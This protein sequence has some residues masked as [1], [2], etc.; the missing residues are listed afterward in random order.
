MLDPPQPIFINSLGIQIYSSY[1]NFF[2]YFLFPSSSFCLFGAKKKSK[3]N[4]HHTYYLKLFTSAKW[5]RSFL[6]YLIS[7]IKTSFVDG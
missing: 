3:N 1:F 6:T 5:S 2:L 7:T 4:N